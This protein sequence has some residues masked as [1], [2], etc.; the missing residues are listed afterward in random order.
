LGFPKHVAR[1]PHT[2]SQPRD[3][4]AAQG[5]ASA[6]AAGERFD[7]AATQLVEAAGIFDRIYAGG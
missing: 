7:P 5:W 4:R 3:S 6:L 2:P 1:R